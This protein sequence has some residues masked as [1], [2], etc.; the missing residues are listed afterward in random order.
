MIKV[1]SE[2]GLDA[3]EGKQCQRIQIRKGKAP[4][5]R[6]VGMTVGRHLE[7]KKDGCQNFTSNTS[8]RVS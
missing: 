1:R 4:K 2:S 5:T 3:R 8:R 7:K 6:D